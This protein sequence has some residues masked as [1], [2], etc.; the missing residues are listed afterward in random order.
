MALPL[1]LV[2]LFA[3]LSAGFTYY[4]A[5]RFRTR[6]LA[7]QLTIAVLVGYVVLAVVLVWMARAA[8]L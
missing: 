3:L 5:A 7:V 2:V 4:A 8:G 6:R 1:V